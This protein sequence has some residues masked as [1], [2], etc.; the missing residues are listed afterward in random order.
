VCNPVFN[1]REPHIQQLIYKHALPG[2]T[3]VSLTKLV[4]GRFRHTQTSDQLEQVDI[5]KVDR[6][7]FS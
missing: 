5:V 4:T 6:K 2:P 1:T 7:Q 3:V